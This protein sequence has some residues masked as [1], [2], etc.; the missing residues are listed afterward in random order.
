MPLAGPRILR[1][2]LRSEEWALVDCSM[3]GLFLYV[4]GRGVSVSR[5]DLCR[6]GG[7]RGVLGERRAKELL[8]CDL[9]YCMS[10][11]WRRKDTMLGIVIIQHFINK[12]FGLTVFKMWIR[13]KIV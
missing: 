10:A 6:H 7:Q 2:N 11:L 1:C 8:N 4:G 13:A 5:G 12:N 3:I 9:L